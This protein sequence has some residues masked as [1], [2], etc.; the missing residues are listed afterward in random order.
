M[1]SDRV[2]QLQQL[3]AADRLVSE[4][5]RRVTFLQLQIEEARSRAVD[6]GDA[7]A[8]LKEAGEVLAA[9]KA[10]RERMAQDLAALPPGRAP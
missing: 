5:Q 8:A 7:W 1:S 9:L 2:R 3:A 4:A 6:V 10:R